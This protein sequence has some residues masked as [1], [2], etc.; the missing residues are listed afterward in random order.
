MDPD[1]APAQGH[2]SPDYDLSTPIDPNAVGLRQKL[3]GYGDA[4]FSLFMRKLFI[5]ALGYSE[6]ALSRPIVGVVNTYS[7]FNPCHSNVPQLIDAV[8]RGVQLSGGLAIDFPTISLHESFSSPTSMYLRNLMS[9]DTEEMIQAQPVDAVVLIGGCDKTTPAQLMGGISANKPIIHLVTGPMM[10]G[11]YQGVRIGA[12]TDC[13]NNWAKF[14]AGALDIEDISALNEELAPTGGTCGVMGTASTM[15]CILVALGMMPINGATAPAVSS[16]RLRIAEATGTHAVQLAKT[17]L[18][19]QTLLTRKS[20]LNAII[21]LQA[22]GGSTNAI[23]H[24]MA[25]ANRH[26]AIAGTINL[27]TIDEFGRTTPLLVDLKPS[28][29]NYMTDFH[30]AGGMLALL[31]ELKPLLHLSALTVTGRT[32]G[33]ELVFTPFRPLPPSPTPII[34]PFASPLYPS[35]SLIVLRGNLAPRGAVMKASASKYTHL[36]QHRGPAVVFTSPSD[37]AS[38]IDSPSL[39]VT[40]S[41]VLILQSIGPVG[42]PGMPEAGLIPIPRK[43]A[44]QGVQDMLRVSD[45]RMSGTA[46]GTIILHISPE[47]ADPDSNLGIV[48]DGDIVAVDAS[49]RTLTLDVSDEEVCRRKAQRKESQAGTGTG[50]WEARRGVRGYRGLYMREVNSA[51]EG[52]DFGFLTAVGPAGRDTVSD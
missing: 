36:L 48:R 20:F 1:D 52:A 17:Q 50:P 45:G 5:K 25:I 33:E 35:S 30:N 46:G 8:K 32:L 31:H 37:M 38:R 16:A 14:R 29:D 34:R 7:S 11:S 41:S 3:P 43:L 13:R 51:E 6:D 44:A 39:D 23:V 4:H 21:V 2:P 18:R 22:I 19:P 24:L 28:G 40:P 10:P 49:N 15:A 9:M 26:P 42:N 47:S 12:C 27:D